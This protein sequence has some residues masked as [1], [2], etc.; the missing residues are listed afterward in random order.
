VLKSLFISLFFISLLYSN[1]I[2]KEFIEY[3]RV[4]E[5]GSKSEVFKAHNGLKIIYM[6]TLM[7]DD[8]RRQKI[9]LK[10]LIKSSKKLELN[11]DNYTNSLRK[12]KSSTTFQNVVIKKNTTNTRTIKTINFLNNSL[13]ILFTKKILKNDI[14]KIIW[15][16]NSKF[17]NIFDIKAYYS[18][19]SI[20]RKI[21]NG[22]S[23]R[24][25]RYTNNITRVVI[26]A[27]YPAKTNFKIVNKQIKI[28]IVNKNGLKKFEVIPSVKQ[29]KFTDKKKINKFSRKNKIIVIDAG[30][31]GKDSGAVGTRGLKEKNIVLKTALK[32]YYELKSRGYTVY[33]TRSR[34]YFIELRDRTKFANDKKADLFISIHANS[35]P[36]RY[37]KNRAHG[38]ETYFLSPTKSTRSMRVAEKENLVD[39]KTMNYFS[40]FTFLNILNRSKILESNK[41]AIDIQNGILRNIKTRFKIKNKGVKKA[42][43]WVLVGA[44]MPSILIEIGYVSHNIEGARLNTRAYQKLIAKGV[45]EGIENYFKNSDS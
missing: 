23:F 16:N 17:K 13:N 12:L 15:K 45:A 33:L 10:Y 26:E 3:E 34:D 35:V 4:L 22:V 20:N 1:S 21:G 37:P 6:T 39:T 43:F 40:K 42:P 41:L 8:K 18:G 44:T 19:K 32:T 36:R 14:K 5:T 11:Y 27:G 7:N 28:F 31:G 24:L 9:A 2:N 30:H 29:L 25:A 38:L